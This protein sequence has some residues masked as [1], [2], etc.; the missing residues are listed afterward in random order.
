MPVCHECARCGRLPVVN[1][2]RL[3]DHLRRLGRALIIF[4]LVDIGI[5]VWAMTAGVP[6]SSSFNIFAVIAGVL[7]RGGNL[8]AVRVVRWYC[9]FVVTA[10]I[11]AVVLIFPFIRPPGLVWAYI[12][13]ETAA[14]LGTAVLMILVIAWLAWI[15]KLT[16]A[17]G[18][19]DALAAAGHKGT[20]PRSPMIAGG[21]FVAMMAVVMPLMMRG[22]MAQKAMKLAEE[23]TGPGY[24]FAVSQLQYGGNHGRASVTAYNDREIKDVEVE[25]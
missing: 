7:V 22:E 25:W 4:G 2:L 5:F 20:L 21:I 9:T 11:G 12:R 15:V 1:D 8:T 13:L 17:K 19:A 18:I 10:F 23:K 3:D 14:A 16:L 6:Y 24:E